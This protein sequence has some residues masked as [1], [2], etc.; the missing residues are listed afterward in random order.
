MA[1]A[2]LLHGFLGAG[3]ST[4]ARRLERDLNA[5]RLSADEWYLRLFTD[6]SPTEGLDQSLN[7]RLL[8]VLDDLWP[9]ILATGV[10]VVLDFGFWSRV[11]R[12]SA[13]RAA[14]LAG[15]DSRLYWVR[16]DEATAARRVRERNADPRDSFYLSDGSYRYLRAK[17]SPLDPDEEFVVV[18]TDEG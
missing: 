12:D 13:R 3:K 9:R 11:S 1:T 7:E 17:Y 15:G 16:C 4:F 18:R 5:V 2:H 14:A 6:G 10:D 8:V